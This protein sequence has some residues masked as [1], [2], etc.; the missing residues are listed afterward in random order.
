VCTWCVVQH[1]HATQPRQQGSQVTQQLLPHTSQGAEGTQASLASQQRQGGQGWGG[2]RVLGS[3]WYHFAGKV[4]QQ[5][6][7]AVDTGKV[8][9]GGGGGCGAPSNRHIDPQGLKVLGAVWSGVWVCWAAVAA[10]DPVH[11]GHKDNHSVG[12]PSCT[13]LAQCNAGDCMEPTE[14]GLQ[15]AAGWPPHLDA[16]QHL[17]QLAA[18]DWLH[19]GCVLHL[20]CC[21]L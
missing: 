21:L 1:Q 10:A 6:E 3:G 9:G 15:A 11:Q 8:G 16:L 20:S 12:M 17:Q 7:L 18:A 13:M 14:Q 2:G 5:R 19:G 4:G